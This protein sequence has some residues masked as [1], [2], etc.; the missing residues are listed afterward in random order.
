MAWL[1][2]TAIASVV[3]LAPPCPAEAAQLLSI[4]GIELGPGEFVDGLVIDTWNV[5]I[6]AICRWPDGWVVEP[7][8][9]AGSKGR[10]AGGTDQDA[11]ALDSGRLDRLHGLVLIE[12]ANPQLGPVT[13]DGVVSIDIRRG[14]PDSEV[15]PLQLSNYLLE[16]AQRCPDSM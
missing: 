7:P 2:V 4:R 3:S 14:E 16:P 11:A 15:W 9:V 12:D 6:L 10:I 8:K 13:F 5:R 1:A